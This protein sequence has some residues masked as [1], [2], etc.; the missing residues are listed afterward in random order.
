[1][2]YLSKDQ[3]CWYLLCFKTL[4]TSKKHILFIKTFN[5]FAAY[6]WVLDPIG[7]DQ[8]PTNSYQTLLPDADCLIELCFGKL[9]NIHRWIFISFTLRLVV[10]KKLDIHRLPF[11]NSSSSCP[12]SPDVIGPKNTS[13]HKLILGKRSFF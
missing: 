5:L 4:N 2:I 6:K 9:I 7:S 11:I 1:M 13:S 8:Q 10:V 12:L 3:N